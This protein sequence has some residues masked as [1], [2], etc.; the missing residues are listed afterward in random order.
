MKRI[1]LSFYNDTL[2][3]PQ[4]QDAVLRVTYTAPQNMTGK[5]R[6]SRFK[7]SKGAFPLF[8][9]GPDDKMFTSEEK[10]QIDTMGMTPTGFAWGFILTDNNEIPCGN[11]TYLLSS[12]AAPLP[13]TPFG[14]NYTP[15]HI[16]YNH[17]YLVE[18]PQWTKIGERW[19]LRN[20]EKPV[21]D[22]NY[23]TE[24]ESEFTLVR[25]SDVYCQDCVKPA[26]HGVE[27]SFIYKDMEASNITTPVNFL[28][29]KA[30]ITIKNNNDETA[31]FSLRA[32][33]ITE[34]GDGWLTP[35]TAFYTTNGK[36]TYS[37]Q[38]EG[39][40]AS[41]SPVPPAK[42]LST[43]VYY[44]YE[45]VTGNLLFPYT[46]IIVTIDE[47]N[48]TGENIVINNPDLSGVIT[49]SVLST[50]K[51]YLVG[52]TN[53]ERSDFVVVDDK[54]N[55]APLVV[56]AP[57]LATLTVRLFMLTKQNKLIPMQIPAGEGFFIQITIEP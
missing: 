5:L 45:I 22:W 23:L 53:S 43:V 30:L 13:C 7:I 17:I 14:G 39:I 24:T 4:N 44:D 42:D 16:V 19:K 40:I 12:S 52:M 57:S 41:N 49:P 48:F 9:L 2:E 10:A 46:A 28:S 1:N 31:M 3:N 38:V 15:T 18:P 29:R 11:D 21:F 55:Q 34:I 33:V 26:A 35:Q 25:Y 50:F 54:L 36:I 47:L 56:T 20:S 32:A 27:F 8:L 37:K 6:A 51:T